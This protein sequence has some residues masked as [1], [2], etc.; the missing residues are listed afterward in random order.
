MEHRPQMRAPL[1]H[2]LIW[3]MCLCEN[4]TAPPY[5]AIQ[6]LCAQLVNCAPCPQWGPSPPSF[7]Q[8]IAHE[9][10]LYRFYAKQ[11]GQSE[12]VWKMITP[13]TISFCCWHSLRAESL[14]AESLRAESLTAEWLTAESL[15]SE[16]LTGE[17]LTGYHPL[18]PIVL[19]L[20]KLRGAWRRRR[21]W[22]E[23]WSATAS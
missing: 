12:A 9:P 14:T 2:L 17:C 21:E 15:T 6:R 4:W 8:N 7:W 18:I 20:L 19:L 23:I 13:D 16:S 3:Q 11:C 22:K 5:M 10:A 1:Q